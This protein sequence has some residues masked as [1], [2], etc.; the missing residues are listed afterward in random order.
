LKEYVESVDY[1]RFEQQSWLRRHSG[2]A[3]VAEHLLLH[4]GLF[5]G[6]YLVEWLGGLLEQIG[7]TTFG[8]LKTPDPNSSLPPACQYSLVVHTSDITR[9]KVVRLPW[10]YPRYGI[11]PDTARVV[12]AVRASMSIPFFFD[13]VQ[14]QASAA[15]YDGVD[16]EAGTV[17]WLDGG[18]LSC[19]PVE[20]FDRTDGVPSRWP[21]IGVKLS[22]RAAV[23]PPGRQCNDTFHEAVDCLHTILGNADRFYITP[24]K[25]SRTIFVDSAAV[26][27]TDFGL[28]GEQRQSLY[29]NGQQAAEAWLAAHP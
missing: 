18:L 5:S 16:Y 23:M 7:I 10:D 1:P 27:A 17:T 3:G 29:N 28:T 8:Q 15:S 12:D 19:F 13:P 20:V 21:T 6:D 25:V 22:A 2:A 24:D 9:G 4:M 11:D 26:T 14:L